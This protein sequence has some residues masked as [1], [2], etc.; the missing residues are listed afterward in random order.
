MY[1]D[2]KLLYRNSIQLHRNE[3]GS[4]S[5]LEVTDRQKY[6]VT[7]WAAIATNNVGLSTIKFLFYWLE[8]LTPGGWTRKDMCKYFPI[9]DPTW[10]PQAFQMMLLF[11]VLFFSK[12][13]L[14]WG[15]TKIG[16]TFENIIVLR[17]GWGIHSKSTWVWVT[18]LENKLC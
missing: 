1:S 14:V 10:I 18:I 17:L 16:V 2:G 11:L 13:W 8:K 12:L 15:Y 9:F 6:I 3:H 4:V 7:Y 5:E